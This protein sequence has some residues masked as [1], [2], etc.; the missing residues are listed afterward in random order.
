MLKQAVVETE[1]A[2]LTSQW[3]EYLNFFLALSSQPKSSTKAWIIPLIDVYVIIK[4]YR[5]SEASI[6]SLTNHN[7]PFIWDILH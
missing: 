2:W 3:Q 6:K 7:S 5:Q 1:A 4:T